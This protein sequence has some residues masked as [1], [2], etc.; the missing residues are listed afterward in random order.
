M[1]STFNTNVETL[2]NVTIDEEFETI[3]PPLTQR[4]Y[5]Q[6]ENV[7]LQ[8][9]E[10]SNPI[11]I[12]NNILLD[13][14]HRRKII[15]NHPDIPFQ[16]K[17]KT[18]ANRDEAIAWICKTQTG[19]RN[20]TPQLLDYLIGKQYK[21]ERSAWGATY[22]SPRHTNHDE[23][24]LSAQNEHLKQNEKTCERIAKDY[25][26][27]QA[28]VRRDGHY[29]TAVDTSDKVCP[30]VKDEFLSG[31]LKATKSEVI[32]L[33]KLPAEDIPA[34]IQEMRRI[35]EEKEAKRRQDKEDKRNK[36]DNISDG[37]K[38]FSS[39]DEL[40]ASMEQPKPRNNVSN[41]IGIISDK[42]EEMMAT[43]EMYITEFPE[44]LNE[45]KPLLFQAL[46]DLKEY[47]NEIYKEK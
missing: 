45:N 42:A 6:L 21:A 20:L 34:A 26:I 1:M 3:C 40:S 17:E 2:K 37:S 25:G 39:I 30:G 31:N 29:A 19:R 46:D 10:V 24:V 14:H 36:L 23:E 44:L 4:E 43:C 12:W 15:L 33:G 22:E 5:E 11:F 35:Q 8:D 38:V 32:A 13:G 7:I 28:S 27:G 41:V 18:F 47:L 9:G 16:I